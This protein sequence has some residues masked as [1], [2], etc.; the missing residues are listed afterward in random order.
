VAVVDDV[1][2]GHDRRVLEA[3]LHLRLAHEPRQ[4]FLRRLLAA[5]PLERHL[6]T[7]AI[8]EREQHLAHPALPE[9]V[10]DRI[11]TAELRH[12]QAANG[13]CRRDRRCRR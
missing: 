11:A 4:L 10:A 13:G 1:V 9:R 6:A 5:H 7:D 3:A 12:R 8:V 2:D